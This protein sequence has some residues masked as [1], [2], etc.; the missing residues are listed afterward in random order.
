MNRG[1]QTYILTHEQD[2]SDNRRE[3]D[4]QTFWAVGTIAHFVVCFELI[5]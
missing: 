3:A 2:A 5:P 4:E 1:V